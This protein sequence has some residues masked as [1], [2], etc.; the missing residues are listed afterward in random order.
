MI[1]NRL[2]EVKKCSDK[3]FIDAVGRIKEIHY[4]YLFEIL[5]ENEKLNELSDSYGRLLFTKR[6]L[7]V[8]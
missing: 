2:V 7:E 8:I 3:R 6:E 4:G 1:E 5:F